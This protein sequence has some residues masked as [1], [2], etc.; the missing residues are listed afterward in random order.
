VI[1]NVA[2][3]GENLLSLA[4]LQARLAA[5]EMRQNAGAAKAAGA[6][7]LAG[8]VLALAG[9]PVLL[10]G[11]AELLVSELA[12]KRGYALL[13]VAGCT[14]VI[15]A[16]FAGIAARSLRRK[17]LGFPL[18]IEELTRNVHWIRTVLK[19]SG[20]PTGRP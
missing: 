4:E 20:R 10:V 15:A 7:L 6:T 11:I 17:P 3:F 12:F 9:V 16:L 1:S 14:L 2:G 18:T 8:S 13:I 5:I 19:H